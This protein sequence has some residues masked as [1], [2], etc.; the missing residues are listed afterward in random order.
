MGI[1]S[2]LGL[3]LEKPTIGCG[4]S[5]LYGRY[6]EPGMKKGDSEPL[7]SRDMQVIGSVL[8]TKPSC[9]PIFVSPGHLIDLQMS[10]DWVLRVLDGYRIPKPTRE[11]DAFVG[12]LRREA[13]EKVPRF[14]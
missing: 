11:A 14:F 9:K 13:S 8:R 7:Y 10:V 4:K 6:E 5:R 1:A 3:L 12:A 2:H